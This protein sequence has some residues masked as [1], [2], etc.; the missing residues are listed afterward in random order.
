M[1]MTADEARWELGRSA[2]ACIKGARCEPRD[3]WALLHGLHVSGLRFRDRSLAVAHKRVLAAIKA[4]GHGYVIADELEGIGS[5]TGL[6]EG[7]LRDITALEETFAEEPDHP[8]M[9]G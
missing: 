1:L 5:A 8:R 4:A 3:L 6:C 7:E 9:A 2:I